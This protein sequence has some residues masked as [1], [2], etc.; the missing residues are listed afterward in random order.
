LDARCWVVHRS[1]R[2]TPV[3]K[4]KSKLAKPGILTGQVHFEQRFPLILPRKTEKPMRSLNIYLAAL[5]SKNRLS[6]TKM[7]EPRGLDGQGYFSRYQ[8]MDLRKHR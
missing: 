3:L 4:Y 1:C 8:G 5:I 2:A 6:L 7:I